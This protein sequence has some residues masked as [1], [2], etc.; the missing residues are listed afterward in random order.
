MIGGRRRP[1]P[2]LVVKKK[3]A[4]GDVVEKPW[5][6]KHVAEARAVFCDAAKK[7]IVRGSDS[8]TRA[9]DGARFG[10]VGPAS[11]YWLRRYLSYLDGFGQNAAIDAAVRRVRARAEGCEVVE[12]EVFWRVKL[13][14]GRYQRDGEN[15]IGAG[16][17]KVAQRFEREAT[18]DANATTHWPPS[19]GSRV[20]RVT[21]TRRRI[22]R[23][24]D[25]S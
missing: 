21:L 13:A 12:V 15:S 14:D 6:E 16:P 3:H 24:K 19:F 25:P 4:A 11:E 23:A 17:A 10:S 1:G 20:V 7:S 18:A 9:L 5:T 2:R 22:V 8:G